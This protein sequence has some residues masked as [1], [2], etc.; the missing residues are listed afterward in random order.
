M[1]VRLT[2][3]GRYRVS[4]IQRVPRGYPAAHSIDS[5][6]YVVCLYAPPIIG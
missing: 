4:G 5:A 1:H 3:P 2:L 6:M